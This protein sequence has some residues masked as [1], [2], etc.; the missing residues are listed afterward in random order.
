MLVDVLLTLV[1]SW[2]V[3]P[4]KKWVCTCRA[5][6]VEALGC[7]EDIVDRGSMDDD[8]LCVNSRRATRAM[9]NQ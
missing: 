5:A 3:N 1:M 4:E 8:D 9:S 6:H 2:F 7:V